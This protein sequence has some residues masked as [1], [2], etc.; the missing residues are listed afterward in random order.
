[1][2]G[3]LLLLVALLYLLPQRE[4]EPVVEGPIQTRVLELPPLQLDEPPGW[5][6]Q[7]GIDEVVRHLDRMSW[8]SHQVLVSSRDSLRRFAGQLAPEILSRLEAIGPGDPVLAA[9]LIELLGNE[10]PTTPGLVDEL[11]RRA[12]SNSALVSKAALR[13]LARVDDERAVEGIV[14]RLFDTD[15]DLQAHARGGLAERARRGDKLAQD[16]VL[17]ELELEADDPDLAFLAVVPEFGASEDVLRV[18]RLVVEQS[19][20][21]VRQVALT[22]LLK[23]GDADAEAAFDEMLAGDDVFVHIEALTSAFTAGRVLGEAHWERFVRNGHREEVL[24]LARLLTLSIDTGHDSALHAMTLLEFLASDGMSPVRSDVTSSLYFR[25]HVW[26][27]EATR[28][29]VQEAI[30]AGL[31][32]AVDRVIDGPAELTPD[33]A[34]LALQRIA[35]PELE[36]SDRFILFRLLSHVAPERSATQI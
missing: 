13:V 12:L 9:K 31:S 36:E 30:G 29:Q 17:D 24:A 10:D 23:L 11:L 26:A 18:L 4:A 19:G 35:D 3:A 1:M 14:A 34:D 8:G 6:R 16:I 22:A 33:F 28:L 15:P 7:R 2:A 5:A 25:R 27:V 32:L 21:A 20:G